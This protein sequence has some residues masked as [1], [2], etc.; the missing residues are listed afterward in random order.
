MRLARVLVTDH[1]SVWGPPVELVLGSAVTALV[2][3]NL[4]GKSNLLRAIAVALDPELP[5]DV[6][7]ERPARRPDAVPTV[8]LSYVDRHHGRPDHVDVTVSF[9]AGTRVVDVRPGGDHDLPTGRP[10]T[11][12]ATDTPTTILARLLDQFAD[13][14]PGALAIDLLPTLQRVIPEIAG[15]ALTF[16]PPTVVAT[17]VTGFEVPVTT[18]RAAFGAALAAH[19]VRRAA[20]LPG[21]VI[22]EPEAFLHPAAQESLRDELLEIAVAADSPVLITAESPFVLPRTP[23]A[24]IIAIAR[25]TIGRTDVV[26]AAA[27]DEPQAALLG[28]LFR[29]GG[30]ATVLDRT[31]RIPAT[32]AGVLIVEGGTDE[33]YLRIAAEV[34]DRTD[35]VDRLAIQPA[36][37]ALPAALEAIVLRAE[38]DL[39]LYVLLDNDE[40]GR[41][42]KATLTD[43]FGFT[44]RQHVTTYAEVIP[45]HPMGAEAEDVFDWRL[46]ERFVTERGDGAIRGKR[47]LRGDEWHFDLTAS[48]KSAFVGWLRDH[49]RPEHLDRWGQVLDLVEERVGRDGGG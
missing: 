31:T 11:V 32:A 18:L 22:E 45:D 41:R 2:G 36:G 38:I 42:A 10:V 5:F 20:D 46:V 44:N 1:R 4:A 23:E 33:A 29:D 30:L 49:A 9:P 34:L 35:V 40:A 37:G 39:P 25:D 47:I 8:R 24:R 21:V 14:D 6:D 19:L 16:D 28:G 13:E 15:L 26:G 17:D 3:P 27:G 43:R 7:R 48:S 12:W